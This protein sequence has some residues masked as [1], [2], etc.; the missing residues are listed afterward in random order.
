MSSI[1][2]SIGWAFP[3]DDYNNESHLIVNSRN[4]L[5]NKNPSTITNHNSFS[6]SLPSISTNRKTWSRI[7]TSLTLT[8]NGWVSRSSFLFAFRF[9]PNTCGY[10]HCKK[11]CRIRRLRFLALIRFCYR[12]TGEID[13][14]KRCEPHEIWVL[15]FWSISVYRI[16]WKI[17]KTMYFMYSVFSHVIWCVCFWAKVWRGSAPVFLVPH[18]VAEQSLLSPIRWHPCFLFPV[19][20]S[21]GGRGGKGDVA[22][23]PEHKKGREWEPK[24]LTLVHEEETHSV[25]CTGH[26]REWKKRNREQRRRKEMKR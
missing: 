21:L 16:Y 17:W 3:N 19:A 2:K 23:Q 26:M 25:R 4:H 22:W 18:F 8:I 9:L 14:A 6:S 7:K 1:W 12:K 15:G 20:S 11:Q 24:P 13:D 5:C 10:L